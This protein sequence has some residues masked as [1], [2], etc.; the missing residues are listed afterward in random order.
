MGIEQDKVSIAFGNRLRVRVC[1]ICIENDK[2]LMVR[3]QSLGNGFLWAPPGG[4]LD[5]GE[6]L[7]EGLQR[8]FVEETGMEVEVV[9]FLFVHEY[10]DK[11]LHGIELFF[12]V[13]QIGGVMKMGT[14]PE[15]SSKDQI[16]DHLKF[17]SFDEI[18][19]QPEGC[20]HNSVLHSNSVEEL[21]AM[22]GIYH[23][24]V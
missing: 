7:E 9:R 21:L 3:H 19:A 23:H 15:M 22:Q 17:L 13:K 12:E 5:F 2:V 8:E 18:K 14:D 4:G 1:G 20:V 10:L 16:I 6:T 24:I 11:P